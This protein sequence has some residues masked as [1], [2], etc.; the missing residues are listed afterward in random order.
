MDVPEPIPATRTVKP[1][2][3]IAQASWSQGKRTP[4]VVISLES[5]DG[6]SDN[7]TSVQPNRANPIQNARLDSIRWTARRI[8][9]SR[10][11]SAA[12]K[13]PLAQRSLD[14]LRAAKPTATNKTTTSRLAM[15]NRMR[16]IARSPDEW[17]QQPSAILNQSCKKENRLLVPVL[18]STKKEPAPIILAD[19]RPGLGHRPG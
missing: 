16:L 2:T 4:L 7:P 6:T 8:E 17:H 10:A 11:A 14:S 12:V 3:E 1:P 5:I 13:I 18:F 9:V 15:V 19:R